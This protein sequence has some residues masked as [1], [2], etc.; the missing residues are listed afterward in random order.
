MRSTL[1]PKGARAEECGDRAPYKCSNSSHGLEARAL[2]FHIF[3]ARERKRRGRGVVPVVMARSCEFLSLAPLGERA[4]ESGD[5]APYKCSNSS[6][7]LEARA[8]KIV[9]SCEETG[10]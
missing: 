2:T 3:E 9:A 6:H 4:E 10:E 8:T 1:S 5:R 7:G